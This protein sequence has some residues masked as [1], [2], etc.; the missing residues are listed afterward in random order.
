MSRNADKIVSS[1]FNSLVIHINT[2]EKIQNIVNETWEYYKTK[3]PEL[4]A[5]VSEDEIKD[6]IFKQ[7][8]LYIDIWNWKN[9]SWSLASR[10]KKSADIFNLYTEIINN[11][12][13]NALNPESL[14]IET[15]WVIWW[16]TWSVRKLLWDK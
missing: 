15:N 10:L 4:Y 16:I 2:D 9:Q 7:I 8:V 11:T 1:T 6:H 13:S 12:Y 3:L 14:D 5:N